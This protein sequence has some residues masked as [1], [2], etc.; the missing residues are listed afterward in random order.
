MRRSDG[1]LAVNLSK[2]KQRFSLTR[3]GRQLAKFTNSGVK[4][5]MATECIR[6]GL[7]HRRR[8]AA[9]RQFA[10][11]YLLRRIAMLKAQQ[12]I[13]VA[14]RRSAP[15]GKAPTVE[16]VIT[17]FPRIAPPEALEPGS[18]ASGVSPG[19]VNDAC[20]AGSMSTLT[21]IAMLQLTPLIVRKIVSLKPLTGLC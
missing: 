1:H 5:S 3:G 6:P 20:R 13:N 17:S 21:V 18:N 8:I 19:L 10:V 14:G 15:P 2:L 9:S 11:D 7:A 16:G 12:Q 4:R